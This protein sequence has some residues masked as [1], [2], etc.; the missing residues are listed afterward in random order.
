MGY[1]FDTHALI[2]WLEGDP[3]F[4][5]SSHERLLSN[6]HRLW[7]SP[8]SF[9]EISVKRSIGKLD[10]SESTDQMWLSIENQGFSLL[11]IQLPHLIQL[12]ELPFHHRDPFDRLLIA[13]A[14]TANLTILTQDGQFAKYDV[15]TEWG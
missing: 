7:V 9:W 10:L 14:Q 8:I 5:V 3:K 13:Q 1:L 2:W 11:P 6:E 15:A 12:E 4:P